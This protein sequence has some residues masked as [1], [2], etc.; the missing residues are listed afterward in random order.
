MKKYGWMRTLFLALFAV[1]VTGAAA[2]H[3]FIDRPEKL[4]AAKG[5]WYDAEGRICA[6]PFVLSD[7][8]GRPLG[9]KR[10]PEEIAAGQERFRRAAGRAAASSPAAGETASR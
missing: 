8:T 2:W 3:W 5:G 7:R 4:C 9:Q 10:T 6:Q 1:G